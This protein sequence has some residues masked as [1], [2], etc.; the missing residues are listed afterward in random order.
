MEEGEEDAF[1][2]L[3]QEEGA[4]ST[5]KAE[6]GRPLGVFFEG[7]LRSS[8]WYQTHT[9]NQWLTTNLLDLKAERP[10]GDLTLAA[11]FRMRYENLENQNSVETEFRELYSPTTVSDPGS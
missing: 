3:L 4:S 11:K 9:P 8:V 1:S 2:D 6:E 10:F 7:E 5:V